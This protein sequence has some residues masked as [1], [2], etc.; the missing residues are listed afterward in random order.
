MTVC[1]CVCVFLFVY[2]IRK[3]GNVVSSA[4]L[5]TQDVTSGENDN[6]VSVKHNILLHVC[7]CVCLCIS[8]CP[9]IDN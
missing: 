7:V 3:A 5:I 6:G 9:F 8:A 2:Q 1:E 4:A